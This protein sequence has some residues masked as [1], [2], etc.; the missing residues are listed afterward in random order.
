M[1][2]TKLQRCN[3]NGDGTLTISCAPFDCNATAGR[4]NTCIL[5]SLPTCSGSNLVTCSA[6]GLE[7]VTPCVLGC[8]AGACCLD[9]DKDSHTDCAGDCN[10]NDPLVFPGQTA[11]Q[12]K[13]S[14]GSF[15][16]DCNKKEELQY[17]N[18]V[19]CKMVSGKCGGDGWTGAIPA[20]GV[21][22]SLTVCKQQGGMCVATSAI[23]ATQGC[24]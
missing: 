4:C 22:G 13:A 24:R 23:F 8:S 5:G 1:T 18:L 14:S 19:S 7:Q 15:D 20:C 12:I 3:N 21:Q 10:D 2:K 17:P 16:Y 9:V 6:A 11:W